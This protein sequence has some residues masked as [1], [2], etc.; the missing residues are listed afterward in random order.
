M[1]LKTQ[2]TFAGGQPQTKA[3]YCGQRNSCVFKL[4]DCGRLVDIKPIACG[5]VLGKIGLFRAL[6]T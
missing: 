1:K 5:S 3:S 2:K 4:S 6:S